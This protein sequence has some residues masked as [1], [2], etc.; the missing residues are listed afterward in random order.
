MATRRRRLPVVSVRTRIVSA[1]ALMA[2]LAVLGAGVTAYAFERSRIL[3]QVDSQLAEAVESLRALADASE[4][5]WVDAEQLLVASLQRI[6][7]D[8]NTGALGVVGGRAALAPP[9]PMHV[10]VAQIEGIAERVTEETAEGRV[11]MGTIVDGPVAFRYVAVPI[12]V[13]EAAAPNDTI[14][15]IGYDLGAELAELDA[16]A[17]SYLVAGAVG[18]L[19]VIV[20]GMVLAGRLLAP[21]RDLRLLAERITAS[22]RSERIPVRGRD[23][24]SQLTETVNAMLDR[25]DESAAAQRRLLDDVGHEL[26]TPITIV[27]G[28]LELMDAS[29]PADVDSARDVAV[30]ELDRMS[31]L[32]QDI[33]G[34]ASLTRGAELQRRATDMAE[35]V[36]QVAARAAGIAGADVRTGSVVQAVASVDA[37]RITQALLQLVQ[38]AITHGAAPI[39]VAS[40]RMPG[41]LQ[42]LV[43]DHGP[44]VPDAHKRAIFERFRRVESGRG[45]EGSGLGLS[46]VAS[47]AVA[48]GGRAWVEDAPEGGAMFGVSIP[49]EDAHETGERGE[50]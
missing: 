36:Q 14:F 37:E 33:A 6:A 44:G 49:D 23:D 31:G 22:G 39:V 35:L 8:D 24:V 43:R 38:N 25:L 27:R 2:A 12:V 20:I 15:V 40:R 26:K 50:A 30:A 1:L 11:V 5:G 16:A 34:A 32:V 28:H 10:D 45:R 13:D 3:D 42:L 19:L 48:H 41:E 29:D 18:L 46:I 7:P 4:G 21:I 17:G 47:I 9:V